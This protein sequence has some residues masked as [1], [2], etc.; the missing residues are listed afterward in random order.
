MAFLDFSC[1]PEQQAWRL[2]NKS[3]GYIMKSIVYTAIA[4]SIVATPLASFAQQNGPLTREQVR[5]ELVQLEKAGYSPESADPY[6]PDNIHAAQARVDAQQRV[7][8]TSAGSSM[9]GSVQ[10]GAGRDNVAR[11]ANSVNSVY[12][13]H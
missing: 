5:A 8:Y 11:P 4:A 3:G 9:S 7:A 13:G 1:G 6:Y 12:F 2:K 10:S